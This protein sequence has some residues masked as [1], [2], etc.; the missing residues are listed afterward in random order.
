MN[1][2]MVVIEL[3]LKKYDNSN[4]VFHIMK[5]LTSKLG[6]DQLNEHVNNSLSLKMLYSSQKSSKLDM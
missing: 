1:D 5:N 4:L 2:T 6:L 3:Q